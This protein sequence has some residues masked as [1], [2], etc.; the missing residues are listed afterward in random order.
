MPPTFIGRSFNEYPVKTAGLTTIHPPFAT[1]GLIGGYSAGGKCGVATGGTG[2]TGAT[3]GVETLTPSGLTTTGLSGGPA[4]K[5]ADKV[6]EKCTFVG[7]ETATN[8]PLPGTVG[9]SSRS[10]GPEATGLV[11]PTVNIPAK[12]RTEV[13]AYVGHSFSSLA[14]NEL[15]KASPSNNVTD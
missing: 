9:T 5:H 6:S 14:T 13:S 7:P 10:S 15:V 8:N 3:A 11:A 4:T 1:T 12:E 2:I